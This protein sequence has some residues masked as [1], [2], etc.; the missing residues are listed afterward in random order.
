MTG[1]E[2]VVFAGFTADL[3]DV[4]QKTSDKL[5]GNA[6]QEYKD[7]VDYVLANILNCNTTDCAASLVPM[8]FEFKYDALSPE[9]EA[10]F[11]NDFQA[12]ELAF[13]LSP[14]RGVFPIPEPSAAV[15]FCVGALVVAES[16]RRQSLP[17]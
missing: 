16:L 3:H 9:S 4:K 7:S 17:R 11:L 15:L 8:A 2:K 10:D 1:S 5:Y 6:L 12:N 13:H 14:E